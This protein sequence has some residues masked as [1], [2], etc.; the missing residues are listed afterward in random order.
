MAKQT[1]TDLRFK[2]CPPCKHK[3]CQQQTY[4]I[5]DFTQ[6]PRV[7]KEPSRRSYKE[8]DGTFTQGGELTS[9]ISYP[10]KAHTSGLCYF[11]LKQSLSLFELKYPLKAQSPAMF[12]GRTE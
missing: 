2:P 5:P 10:T 4:F 9:T 7:Y 8:A 1:K 11:H 6:P 12:D 3:G